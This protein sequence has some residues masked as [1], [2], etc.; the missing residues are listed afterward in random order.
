[1]KQNNLS[2][3]ANQKMTAKEIDLKELLN[4]VKKRIWLVILL[5]LITTVAGGTYKYMT[6]TLLYQA[7]S[8]IIIEADTD[9]RTTLQVIIKDSTILEKVVKE[10]KLEKAPEALAG[11][12]TVQ[13]IN[14]SQV[15]SISVVDSDPKMA[16]TIANTVAKVFKA[17]IPKIVNFKDVRFLSEAKI[18]PNPING[19]QTRSIII[20]FIF[21]LAAGIGL[22]FFLHSLDD[23]IK[24]ERELEELLGLSALGSISKMNKRNIKKRNNQVKVNVRG[25][26]VGSK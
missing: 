5:T 23:S 26:T 3:N 9:Y 15:T 21:G 12:I 25:E 14:N 18:N 6:T 24:S 16:A 17:E 13:S 2:Q 20:F 8:R 19:N 22:V 10:L 4:I 1:M 11:Q 7:S